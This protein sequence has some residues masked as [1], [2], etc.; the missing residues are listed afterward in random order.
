[1]GVDSISVSVVQVCYIET[2]AAHL[3]QTVFI[4]IDQS[5]AIGVYLTARSVIRNVGYLVVEVSVISAECFTF[6]SQISIVIPKIAGR[7]SGMTRIHFD[8][9]SQ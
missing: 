6:L 3:F 4:V 2:E 5:P 8:E 7:L 9:P 1:M